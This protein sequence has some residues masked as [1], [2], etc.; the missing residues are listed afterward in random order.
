MFASEALISPEPPGFSPP[1]AVWPA[2][3]EQGR[4]AAFHHSR[5]FVL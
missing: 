5:K 4:M 2:L 1:K 3:T